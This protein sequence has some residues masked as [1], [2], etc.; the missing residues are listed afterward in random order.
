MR[1]TY[2]QGLSKSPSPGHSRG[3]WLMDTLLLNR[4][5]YFS[6]VGADSLWPPN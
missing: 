4:D 5:L 3:E 2:E 6:L 1:P